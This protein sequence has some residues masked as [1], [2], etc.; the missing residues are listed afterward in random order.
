MPL[1]EKIQQRLG[2]RYPKQVQWM[3]SHTIPI[4]LVL[5][6]ILCTPIIYGH[7]TNPLPKAEF[8][9]GWWD[10]SPEA[11]ASN[12][13]LK[14]YRWEPGQTTGV[15]TPPEI[16]TAL[17]ESPDKCL[18]Y[19][20]RKEHPVRISAPAIAPQGEMTP[21][22]DNLALEREP[23]NTWCLDWRRNR[24]APVQITRGFPPD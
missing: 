8:Y 10:P 2:N 16:P 12:Y 1:L 23:L 7:F 11:E 15:F 3:R 5:G 22:E 14:E 4:S 20:S 24:I 18:L 21:D 17:T 19:V 6:I 13:Y 9:L